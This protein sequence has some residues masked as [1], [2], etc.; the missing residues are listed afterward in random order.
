MMALPARSEDALTPVVASPLRP[1]TFAVQGTD[2]KLHLVY[3]L[4]I[5]NTGSAAAT[6]EKIEV[7]SG[8]A[9]AKVFASFDGDALPARLRAT[10]RGDE[11]ASPIESSGG[12][13]FLLDFTMDK[14]SHPLTTLLHRFSPGR[15]RASGLA[16]GFG[17]RVQWRSR[18]ARA[19]VCPAR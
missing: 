6:I 13:L 3:E 8:D 12:R 16:E 14:D 7:V 18:A 9:S 10:G 11:A 19:G 5:T 17:A 15:R 4:V 1:T 2:H